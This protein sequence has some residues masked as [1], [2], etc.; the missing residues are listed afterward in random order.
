MGLQ[1]CQAHWTKR[2]AIAVTD[3]ACGRKHCPAGPWRRLASAGAHTAAWSQNVYSKP[4]SI[5]DEKGEGQND[6]LEIHHQLVRARIRFSAAKKS[7]YQEWVCST[8]FP[9]ICEAVWFEVAGEAEGGESLIFLS[10]F[11]SYILFF[12]DCKILHSSDLKQP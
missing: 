8:V 7:L 12:F 1:H 5:T 4:L 10:H 2:W 9:S 11:K 3:A 6:S